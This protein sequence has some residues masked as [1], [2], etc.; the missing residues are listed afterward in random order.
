MTNRLSQTGATGQDR[1]EF[2]MINRQ[3]RCSS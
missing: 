3:I 1:E 2:M